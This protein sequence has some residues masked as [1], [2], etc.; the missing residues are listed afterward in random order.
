MNL[1]REEMLRAAELL[2]GFAESNKNLSD[3]WNGICGNLYRNEFQ[4]NQ[5]EWLMALANEW[6]EFSGDLEYPVQSY[7][8]TTPELAYFLRNKWDRRTKYGK[9]RVR[10]CLFLAQR[11]RELAK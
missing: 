11:L 2:E 1:T 5:I 9:A 3:K 10:L 8:L 6:T 7:N 4:S